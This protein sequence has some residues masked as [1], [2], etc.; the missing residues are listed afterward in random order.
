[1][2]DLLEV[3]YDQRKSHDQSS[4]RGHERKHNSADMDVEPEG[5]PVLEGE[6]CHDGKGQEDDKGREHEPAMNLHTQKQNASE[7]ARVIGA[8]QP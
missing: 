5:L 3:V 2:D 7:S 1:M 8:Q 4:S 6:R